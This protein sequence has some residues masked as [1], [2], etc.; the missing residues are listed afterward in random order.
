MGYFWEVD[1]F[2]G[3]HAGL[4][5]TEIELQAPDQP[6][7]RPAWLGEEVTDDPR[8]FNSALSTASVVPRAISMN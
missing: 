7:A 6:F 8:Y 5:L 2:G 1:E 4:V 3:A